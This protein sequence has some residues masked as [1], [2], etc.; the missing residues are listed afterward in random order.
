MKKHFMKATAVAVFGLVLASCNQSAYYQVYDVE[1]NNLRQ[2]E[3]SL[4]YENEDCKV[5]YNLWS[6][7]GDI[8]F[9][10][11]NKTDKDIFINMG[12]TFFIVNG[13]A[14]DYFYDRTYTESYVE[15]A[16]AAVAGGK[17]LWDVNSYW[18]DSWYSEHGKTNSL[19]GLLKSSDAKGS[20]TTIKEKEII[21][22]PAHCFKVICKCSVNPL[23]MQTCD[24]DNDYPS[25]KKMIKQYGKDNS[26]ITFK[27]RIAYGFGKDDVATK[28]IDND[29]WISC[30]TNYSK[31]GAT[32]K[33]TEKTE[34]YGV[35]SSKKVRRF[36]IG[37]PNKFYQTYY[38]DL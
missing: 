13:Q 6:D 25:Q 15:S 29:F 22:V 34:C 37:G 33:M 26:P 24:K 3:N 38:N 16:T 17:T 8:R 4:V 14:K 30:V 36:K 28:H 12:Q 32:E 21:C 10:F 20:A 11:H 18:G 1:A 23:L 35:K 19:S 27:N 9:A 5:L 2:K 7:G 31:K